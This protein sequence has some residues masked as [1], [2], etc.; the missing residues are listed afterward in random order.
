LSPNF[1]DKVYPSS[2]HKK[3]SLLLL[4]NVT[5]WMQRQGGGTTIKKN[6]EVGRWPFKGGGYNRR[7]GVQVGNHPPRVGR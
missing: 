5:L 1:R 7:E 2:L 3:G 6:M 4:E